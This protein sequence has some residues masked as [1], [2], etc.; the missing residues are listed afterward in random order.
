MT[1]DQITA[2]IH[3][4]KYEVEAVNFFLS[5]GLCAEIGPKNGE[6]NRRWGDALVWGLNKFGEIQV[7]ED[8]TNFGLNKSKV[9]MFRGPN[10]NLQQCFLILGCRISSH[11]PDM[12]FVLIP[13]L[14]DFFPRLIEDGW[15]TWRHDNGV[16]LK[17]NTYYIIPPRALTYFT[18]VRY[19][20]SVT[21]VLSK[22]FR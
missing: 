11:Y 10:N 2:M 15:K 13:Y 3:F 5:R 18:G 20:T 12:S 14:Q 4:A 17:D 6:T 8:N 21:D 16:V 7:S 9:E 19:G 22:E 1:Q